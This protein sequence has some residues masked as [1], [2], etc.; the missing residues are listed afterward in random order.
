MDIVGKKV[1]RQVQFWS[2]IGPFL[3][4]LSITVLLF[5]VSA[6]WYFSASALIGIPLCVKWKMKGMALSLG[7]LCLFSIIGYQALELD[8]RYW[9]VGLSLAMA[10]SFIVLTL[11][12]EEV[13]GLIDKVELES[14][15][16]LDNVVLLDEKWKIAELEWA[17]EKEKSKVE[18]AV[19]NQEI[20]RVQEDKQNFYKLSQLAKEELVQVKGQHDLLLQDLLYKKQQIS[21]LHERLEE[22]EITIQEFVNSDAEKQM[23]LLTESLAGLEKEKEFLKAKMA[24][25]GTE[26]QLLLQE[27]ERLREELE[28]MQARETSCLLE[29]Q[30][31]LQNQNEQQQ[32]L[33]LCQHKCQ[34][35]EQEKNSWQQQ[36]EQVRDLETQHR[37][38]IQQFQKKTQELETKFT[39][40]YQ[41]KN[42]HLGRRKELEEQL[43]SQ[44]KGY[45]K[46]Y[47]DLSQ[48]RQEL[49]VKN[50]ALIDLKQTVE[51]LSTQLSQQ[52]GLAEHAVQQIQ[53]MEEL[54][55]LLEK[56]LQETQAELKRSQQLFASKSPLPYAP[57]NTRQMETM[58][59]QLKEQFQEKCA[60][61][62]ATRRELFLAN[63]ELLKWQKEDEEEKVFGLSGNEHS[64]QRHLLQVSKHYEKVEK[65]HQQE[66]DEMLEL[67]KH[68]LHQL[69]SKKTI[70]N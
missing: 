54:K 43:K 61:L 19:L 29:R 45:Q 9:H 56:N 44:E 47:E 63:E 66:I 8:E 22:T 69:S 1:E 13:Q 52:K 2:L 65:Q 6:H 30:H 49:A 58:Y 5:K 55:E 53:R 60:T 50:D 62:D 37:Q 20:T 33:Q 4:L 42:D 31:L 41:Q 12:L 64:L 46:T 36:F 21:Q 38:T 34:L 35:V 3:I 10:F 26:S 57:G 59:L 48:A 27:T 25:A 18:V 23:E 17:N 16:R 70:K 51:K 28:A 32:A 15:S 7:C 24:L 11:S 67:I 40:E 14:Q 39:E 68:L